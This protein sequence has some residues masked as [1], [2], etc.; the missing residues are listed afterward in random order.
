MKAIPDDEEKKW[1]RICDRASQ[2]LYVDIQA[3]CER[4]AREAADEID[5]W[6]WHSPDFDDADDWGPDF[7]EEID[8]DEVCCI[9][10][11]FR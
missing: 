1:F 2:Y 4:S 3:D 5:K 8:A 6:L 7:V 10:G 9:P 11:K